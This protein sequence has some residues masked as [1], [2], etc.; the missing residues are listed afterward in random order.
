MPFNSAADHDLPTMAA[1]HPSIQTSEKL[2]PS[3]PKRRSA[4]V[5][6]TIAIISGLIILLLLAGTVYVYS[7]R[8]GGVNTAA[9][10]QTATVSAAKPTQKPTQAATPTSTPTPKPQNG[11]YIAGTYNGS[12]TSEITQQTT[13]ITVFLGQTKGSGALTGTFVVR[14]PQATYPLTGTDD[15]QGNFSFTVQQPAGQTPLV[16]YGALQQGV[17]LVGHF[18]NSTTNSCGAGTGYFTAGPRY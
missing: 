1:S 4:P 8:Q 16:F 14:S 2:P 7:S 6:R 12:M 17:Y 9:Q 11:L 5:S 15:L 10:S 18:C 3:P 13:S